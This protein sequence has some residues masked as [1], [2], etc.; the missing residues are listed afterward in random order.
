MIDIQFMKDYL[1]NKKEKQVTINIT[2][3]INFKIFI[4]KFNFEINGNI[5]KIF[6]NQNEIIK[7]EFNEVRN[8]ENIE[9]NKI[10]IYFN[11]NEKIIIE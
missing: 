3:I 9:D 7:I 4:K 8:V 6:E 5:L 2:G 10:L 1:K 11:I